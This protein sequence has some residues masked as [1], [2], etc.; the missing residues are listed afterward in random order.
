[1]E[2]LIRVKN[3]YKI[4]NPGENEVRALDDVSL[5]INQGEFI[6]ES[7]VQLSEHPVLVNLHL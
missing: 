4:Y 3:M 6:K 7:F 5:E 1:M 2:P